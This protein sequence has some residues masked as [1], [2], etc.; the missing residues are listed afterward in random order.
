MIVRTEPGLLGAALGAWLAGRPQLD[1][2]LD[3]TGARSASADQT[4]IVVTSRPVA[5]TATVFLIDENGTS[6]SVHRGGTVRTHLYLG[7]ERLTSLI[8]E[9]RGPPAGVTQ[10]GG[11]R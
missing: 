5:S 9:Q 7:L 1:V 3:A 4:D 11:S 10:K 6:I 2:V 8:E